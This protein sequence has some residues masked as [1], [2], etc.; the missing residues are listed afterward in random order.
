MTDTSHASAGGPRHR[1]VE[2]GVAIAIIVFGALVMYGSLHVGI[3][4]G[5]EGPKSGF[6]PFYLGVLI[7]LSSVMNLVTAT[8]QDQQQIFADWS[9]LMSVL[10]VVVPTA[11]YVVAVP[12]TGI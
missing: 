5:A 3:G 8:T 4:W 10:S 2:L 12:W 6:F 9:Q 1:A 11:V 7:V